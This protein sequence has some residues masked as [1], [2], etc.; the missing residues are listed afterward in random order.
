[1]KIVLASESPFRKRA[2][3]LLGLPYETCPSRIDEKSIRDD[4]PAAL[5]RKLAEA[6]AHTVATAH[7]DALIISGDAVVLKNGRILEKPRDKNEAA[8]MLR[9]LSGGDFQFVTAVAVFHAP[10]NRMLT[11]VESCTIT[12]RPLL[13]HEIQNYIH[14]YDVLSCAGAFEGDGVLLFAEGISG[15]YNIVT[16]LPISPLVALLRQQGLDI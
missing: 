13:D 5:T 8:Q 16:A 15:A 12:F 11:A 3:D 6:K 4:D 7:P 14:K 1:M 2:L 10:Q 9:Q